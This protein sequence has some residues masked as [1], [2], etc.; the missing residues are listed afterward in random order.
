M[1][2]E[3]EAV[4]HSR[5][6]RPFSTKRLDAALWHV[7]TTASGIYQRKLKILIEP[8]ATANEWQA[9]LEQLCAE[10]EILATEYCPQA[11]DRLTVLHRSAE[12]DYE[13]AIDAMLRI[14]QGIN[15]ETPAVAS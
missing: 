8:P 7:E 5:L 3:S 12:Q 6:L 1:T 13:R 14:L 4:R 15:A 11:Y 9:E 10:L 2:F